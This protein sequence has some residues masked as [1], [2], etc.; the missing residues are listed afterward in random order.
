[1]SLGGDDDELQEKIIVIF[2][3]NNK[4]YGYRRIT[5]ELRNQNIIVNHKK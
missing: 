5:I 1:M 2:N 3:K 4:R